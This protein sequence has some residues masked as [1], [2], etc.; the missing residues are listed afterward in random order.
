MPICFRLVARHSGMCL[1]VV[2]A[3]AGAFSVRQ[4]APSEGARAQLW[5]AEVAGGDG[6]IVA[7]RNL[8]SGC[9][10][11]QHMR[12][13]RPS[14]DEDP[15]ERVLLIPHASATGYCELEVSWRGATG[16]VVDVD[17]GSMRADAPAILW[18]RRS[19]GTPRDNELF[20]LQAALDVPRVSPPEPITAKSLAAEQ[21]ERSART[22]HVP[23]DGNWGPPTAGEMHRG[24]A[25]LAASCLWAEAEERIAAE[26]LYVRY[27]GGIAKVQ[28]GRSFYVDSDG[29]VLAGWHG[30]VSPPRG[31]DG[32]S[33]VP[34]AVKDAESS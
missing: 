28:P 24:G 1:A 11:G 23:L 14:A 15:V 26:E 34:G 4:V 17:Q 21:A 22:G 7:L 32:E 33:M 10:L 13:P 2:D 12:R 3:G 9:T 19:D 29:R 20:A 8:A 6:S 31:M 30:T 5:S 18:R 27:A 16:Q 25:L